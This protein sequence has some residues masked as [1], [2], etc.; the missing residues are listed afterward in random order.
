[1][2]DKAIYIVGK[3]GKAAVGVHLAKLQR[4][5]EE[6]GKELIFVDDESELPNTAQDVAPLPDV[7]DMFADMEAMLLTP[8]EPLPELPVGRSLPAPGIQQAL[9]PKKKRR[10]KAKRK[11]QRKARKRQ[12][13]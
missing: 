8:N 11:V 4:L 12:R 7:E 10:R 9:S 3:D 1:M 5:T 13:R 2:D 6:M